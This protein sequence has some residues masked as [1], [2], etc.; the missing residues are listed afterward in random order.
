GG[1]PSLGLRGPARDGRGQGLARLTGLRARIFDAPLPTSD[2]VAGRRQLKPRDDPRTRRPR[3][4]RDE[5]HRRQI[6]EAVRTRDRA[7]LRTARTGGVAL[8]RSE[9]RWSR[10]GLRFDADDG[11]AGAVCPRCDLARGAW[12]WLPDCVDRAAP[13]RRGPCGLRERRGRSLRRPRHCS[14]DHEP[15]KSGFPG[16]P[17]GDQLGP[18]DRDRLTTATSRRRP[19][20]PVTASV[21]YPVLIVTRRS[22]PL[23]ATLAV[24]ASLAGP[25]ASGAA[26]YPGW[27]PNVPWGAGCEPASSPEVRTAANC[28]AT[29]VDGE[30]VPPSDAPAVVKR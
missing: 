24:A 17:G 18:A 20:P 3:D 21:P 28:G 16:N 14:R 10:S 5:P 29:L 25:P 23:L 22:I 27:A 11:Q 26:D 2:D 1:L 8:L 12:E 9:A 30:A 4:R 6:D 13:G 15:D 7:H 19:R